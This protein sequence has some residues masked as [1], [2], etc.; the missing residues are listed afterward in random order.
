ML[1][2][3]AM[4]ADSKQSIP[5]SSF[6]NGRNEY[7]EIRMY[8]MGMQPVDQ[9]KKQLTSDE[10]IDQSWLNIQNKI[11]P[12]I[13]KYR[14]IAISK[15]MQRQYDITAF[16]IDEADRSAEDKYYADIRAKIIMREAAQGTPMANAP[17][18]QPNRGEPE[19]LEE[20]EIHTQYGYKFNMAFEAEN[21]VSLVMNQN[22]HDRERKKIFEYLFDYGIAGYK[23]WIDEKGDVK[24][25][26]VKA[27]RLIPSYCEQP[28]FSDMVHCGEII[29][30]TVNDLAAWF[31]TAELKQICK[32]V[33][34]KYGNPI[35]NDL[36]S[37]IG[38]FKVLVLDGQLKTT[39][40]NDYKENVDNRNNP[41]FGK[42]DPKEVEK[43]S[44]KVKNGTEAQYLKS[45]INVN[46]QFKWVVD[47]EFLYDYGKCKNQKRKDSSWWDTTLD[48]HLYAWNFHKMQFTGI[49]KRL[50]PSANEYQLIKMR[51]EDLN[52]KLIPYLINIDLDA[53][54]NVA[55]GKS[56]ENMTPREV[57]DLMM[58]HRVVLFRGNSVTNDKQNWKP[59]SIEP[60]GQLAA[61]AQLYQALENCLQEIRNISGFN[62]LT[63]GTS[64]QPKMLNGVAKLQEQGTNNALWLI[65]DA[66]KY[67]GLQLA[68]AIV[69]KVQIAVQIGKVEGYAK[70]LGSNMIKFFKINPD[71]AMHEFGIFFEDVPT[72]A[73]RQD[74]MNRLNLKDSQGLIDPEDIVILQNTRNLKEAQMRLAYKVKKRRQQMQ[75]EAMQQQQMNGQVQVQSAQA[76]EE[77]KRKTLVLA[78]QLKIQELN[79]AGQWAYITSQDKTMGKSYDTHVMAQAKVFGQQIAANAKTGS[80][81]ALPNLIEPPIHAPAPQPQMQEPPQQEM[82]EPQQEPPMQEQ[83][84]MPQ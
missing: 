21:A 12:I 35:W 78:N 30:V 29:D 60:S 67:L 52:A 13:P 4:W 65:S 47:T 53:L 42:V 31:S 61:F 57:M 45:S 83:Q 37:D 56:G 24:Y 70:A 75:Q 7:D 51:L 76:A 72:D 74:L 22:K 16:A 10:S 15:M 58:Q 64:V 33:E 77:E 66:E 62:E 59:A 43:Q 20:L 49:T 80:M 81:A 27:E 26:A 69:Q 41:R 9:Y 1:Y 5:S 23:E 11:Y 50:I 54:D 63:D 2:A 39:D 48:W 14:E 68:D 55:L 82:G 25:R 71:I 34:R 6:Y 40:T 3:K 73:D 46:Y 36:T 19:D 17:Q 18:L 84:E 8:A 44:K 28:D 32:K 38:K 79:V